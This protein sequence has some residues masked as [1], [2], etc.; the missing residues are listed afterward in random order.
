MTAA[1]AAIAATIIGPEN[2]QRMMVSCWPCGLSRTDLAKP[3]RAAAI[4]HVLKLD[5]DIVGISEIE[6]RCSQGTRR[7]A[8]VV[9]PLP[10]PHPAGQRLDER[11]N[12]VLDRFETVVDQ[13][14]HGAL[15]VEIFDGEARVIDAGNRVGV[16]GRGVE[17]DAIRSLADCKSDAVALHCANGETERRLVEGFLARPV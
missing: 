12:S 15:G 4:A 9:G 2:L 7:A 11:R 14:C 3:S 10:P 6:F 16:V 5:P 17:D 13:D 8:A 1:L